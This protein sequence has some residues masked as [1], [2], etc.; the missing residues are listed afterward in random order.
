MA[1]LS[2]VELLEDL[3]AR[4]HRLLSAYE[5]GLRRDAIDAEL[6]GWLLG[7]ERE[8][9]RAIQ[10]TLAARGRRN[11]RA[12]AP[13][14]ELNAAVRSRESFAGYAID[15]E[16]QA[17]DAYRAAAAAI[18]DPG[19]RQPLGSIM[20]CTAAHVVALRDSV[21]DRLLLP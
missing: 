11:P 17:A 1:D 18:R 12:T 15:L 20:A 16:G 13:P 14:P 4:E 3:L 7:H 8:H 2:Y 9:V 21:G 6:G 19:L 10:Q 5:A